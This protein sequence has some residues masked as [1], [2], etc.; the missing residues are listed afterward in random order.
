MKSIDRLVQIIQEI[1]SG[2]YSND[3][4]GLTCE[5]QPET[6]RTIAEAMGLMMVKVE[7][8][9]YRLELM[10]KELEALNEKIKQNTIQAVST[11]AHALEARD[12]YT[13]GHAARVADI[14]CKIARQMGLAEEEIEFIRLGG[15]LH[16][17]GKIG[18]PDRLFEPHAHKNPPD[19]VKQITRHPR[20]GAEILRDLDFLGPALEYVHCHHERPDGKGYPRHLKDEQIPLGARILAVADAFDAMTTDR[21]YQ[22]GRRPEAAL[23]ILKKSAGKKWDDRCVSAFDAVLTGAKSESEA[24]EHRSNYRRPRMT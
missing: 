7:A 9:E 6:V 2:E 10:V 8:R 23:D 16:D 15:I 22:K 14:A 13:E 17:I 21:P 19:L 11:M 4:M 20:T 5:D 24:D 3:I 1:S 18:F 12:A